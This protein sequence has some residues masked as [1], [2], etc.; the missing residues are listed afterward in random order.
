MVI[1]AP[2]TGEKNRT[3]PSY[4]EYVSYILP[5]LDITKY[6]QLLICNYMYITFYKHYVGMIEF[7]F[8]IK[9]G[10]SNLNQVHVLLLIPL[11][12]S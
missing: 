8:Q 9:S 7:F 10:N 11:F 1:V 2:V 4:I 3:D 5:V 12:Y 6:F